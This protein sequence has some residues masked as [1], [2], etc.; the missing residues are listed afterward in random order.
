MRE[1]IVRVEAVSLS[2]GRKTLVDAASLTLEAGH[3][4]VLIGP[5]GAG[6]SSLLKLMT[7]ESVPSSGRV[8]HGGEALP[9][10]PGWRLA[11]C[12]AVM[13]QSE[14][15]SFPFTVLDVVRMGQDGVGRG[16]SISERSAIIEAALGAADVLHLAGR[17]Y[18]TLSGGER[19]RAQ[20]AR[21]LCQLEA[22]RSL[23][24]PQ[25]LYLDEPVSSLDLSHQLALLDQVKRLTSNGLA[26]LCVLHDLNM[27]ISFA[28]RL[29][30]MKDGR[31]VADG[32]PGVIATPASIAS[33]FSVDPALIEAL[34]DGTPSILPQRA[35]G[36][37]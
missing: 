9:G 34:P 5:N 20:F 29:V 27:A 19:Q 15:L 13:A 8:F 7:G 2:I 30:M 32:A 31:V 10:I 11:A 23:R 26:V 25:A 12:R 22:G 3:L 21:A 24:L 36:V 28:D 33:V 18:Q 14:S 17:R 37:L 35:R 16:L 6:K 4:T 1:E